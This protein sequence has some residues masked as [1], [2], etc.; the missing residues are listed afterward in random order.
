MELDV[1]KQINE[2]KMMNL[3][4]EDGTKYTLITQLKRLS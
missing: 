3:I 2:A 1:L 4:D